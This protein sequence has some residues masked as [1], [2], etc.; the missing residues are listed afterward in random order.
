MRNVEL[1]RRAALFIVVARI[2]AA[3]GVLV[4]TAQSS[5]RQDTGVHGSH[6]YTV[7]RSDATRQ[8]NQTRGAKDAA[9][10]R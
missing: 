1:W 10:L 5:E 4:T 9:A 8:V 3:C 6:L 7:D 2:I